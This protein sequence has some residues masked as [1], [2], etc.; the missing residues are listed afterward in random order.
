MVERTINGVTMTFEKEYDYLSIRWETDKITTRH[1][2]AY[3]TLEEMRTMV[4]AFASDAFDHFYGNVFLN[5]FRPGDKVTIWEDCVHVGQ[6]AIVVMFDRKW[7][8]VRLKLDNGAMVELRPKFV[9]IL[10]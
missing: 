2:G 10:E 3:L 8:T 9:Q 6:T 5:V 4:P 1:N 7:D